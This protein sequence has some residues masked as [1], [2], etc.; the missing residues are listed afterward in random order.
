V[1]VL[2]LFIS[3]TSNTL[4]MLWTRNWKSVVDFCFPSCPLIW[5]LAPILEQSANYSVSSS[6]TGGRTFWMGDQLVAM[7]L[8]KHRTTQARKTRTH[9]KHPNPRRDSKPESRPPR[10]RR[11]FMPQIA[12]LPRPP[13]NIAFTVSNFLTGSL[14]T[15]TNSE[16]R[17][18]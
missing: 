16:T 1:F 13:M 10:D 15:T 12:R 17:L 3:L 5:E 6:F 9:I 8:S 7:P 18:Q 14:W 4:S 2:I 11:M